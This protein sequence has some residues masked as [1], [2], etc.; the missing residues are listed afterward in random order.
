ME[1]GNDEPKNVL[2]K[3][4][5]INVLVSTPFAPTP[6]AMSFT[7]YFNIQKHSTN[8]GQRISFQSFFYKAIKHSIEYLVYTQPTRSQTTLLAINF[9]GILPTC[10]PPHSHSPTHS[11]PPAP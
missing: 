7:K 8:P 5:R 3:P 9:G 1:S 10:P 11:S 6:Y 4:T 2:R